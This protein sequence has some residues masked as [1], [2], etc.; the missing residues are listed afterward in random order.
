V[1]RLTISTCTQY[2]MLTV[3][4]FPMEV[5]AKVAGLGSSRRLRWALNVAAAS[6]RRES[7]VAYA[8]MNSTMIVRSLLLRQ[9]NIQSCSIHLHH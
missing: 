7:R 9:G 1:A 8:Q 2:H 4:G 5:A 3:A 6:Q